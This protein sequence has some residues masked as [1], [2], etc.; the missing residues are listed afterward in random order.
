MCIYVRLYI[1]VCGRYE[2]YNFEVSLYVSLLVVRGFLFSW[3]LVG[4]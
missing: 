3:G 1:Y 4:L 2:G